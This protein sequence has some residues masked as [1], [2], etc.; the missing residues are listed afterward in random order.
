MCVQYTSPIIV[1]VCSICHL[2]NIKWCCTHIFH[3][4][5]FCCFFFYLLRKTAA[6]VYLF[7]TVS[8]YCLCE[9]E[10]VLSWTKLYLI[11]LSCFWTIKYVYTMHDRGKKKWF[12]F[13]IYIF[14]YKKKK[15]LQS[16][17]SIHFD[18]F[19]LEYY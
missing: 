15:Q 7:S 12:P 5:V 6:F 14:I 1:E 17:P 13:T 16:Q 2:A 8:V 19:L 18:D 3:V 9:G 11:L 4:V 10:D